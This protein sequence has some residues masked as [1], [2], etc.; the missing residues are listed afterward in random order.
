MQLLIYAKEHWMDAVGKDGLTG[1]E[2]VMLRLE[3][4]HAPQIK[5]DAQMAKFAARYQKGDIV[6][7]QP[8]GFRKNF[9]REAFELVNVPGPVDKSLM[10]AQ[11]DGAKLVKRRKFNVKVADV[12]LGAERTVATKTAL[13]IVDKSKAAVSG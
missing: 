5:I 11:W 6:E 9:N 3:A 1:H 2:R 7:V 12:L 13:A 4:Q 10:D 8:D